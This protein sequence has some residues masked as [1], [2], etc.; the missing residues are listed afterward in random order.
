MARTEE[1]T[2]VVEENATVEVV[3]DNE[4]V[5]AIED[6][7]GDVAVVSPYS[8]INIL[9]GLTGRNLPTQMA[10]NYAKKGMIKTSTNE[11]GKKVVAKADEVEFIAKYI[12]KNAS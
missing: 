9:N 10:Y 5:A 6:V 2:A 4:L 11:L 3:V 8:L 1:T 12:A 7:F